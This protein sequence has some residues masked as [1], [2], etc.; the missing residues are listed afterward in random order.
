[1][2][3]LFALLLALCLML[4]GAALAE[5][6]TAISWE[7]VAP[8]LESAG[9]TGEF[10]TFEQIAVAIFIP[11]GMV[12]AELPDETYI[13]YF[14]DEDG[15][16]IALQYVNAEGM[17]L[18]SLA[19]TLESVGATGI[20]FGTVNGLPCVTYEMPENQSVNIAF[21]T[22]AG[23]ILEVVCAPMTSDEDKLAASFVLSSI[24]STAE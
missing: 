9:V 3:K 2:K 5:E 4:S 24:Q 6:T 17:D 19:A 16:A 14:T 15:S 1:M 10:Y 11:E 7:E 18:E 20:E 22:E 21:T 23:Y 12:E 8:L 13:G